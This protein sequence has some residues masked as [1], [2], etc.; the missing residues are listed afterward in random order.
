MGKIRVLS[1]GDTD[2]LPNEVVD[3]FA[4][5]EHN[6]RIGSMLRIT[7]SGGTNLPVGALVDKDE[8]KE[9][10]SLA[11]AEGEEPAKTKRGRPA[12]AKTLL[13]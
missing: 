1:P 13:L 3:K 7:D 5:R 6:D 9:A 8:V 4:F 2:L 10:N 12:T 11:E